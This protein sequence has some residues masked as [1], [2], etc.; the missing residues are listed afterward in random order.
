MGTC[1]MCGLHARDGLHGRRSS[2]ASG[3]HCIDTSGSMVKGTHFAVALL[4]AN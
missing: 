1:S 2:S 3:R 4:G